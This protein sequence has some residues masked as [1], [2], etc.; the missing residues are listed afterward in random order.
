MSTSS[1]VQMFLDVSALDDANNA[2]PRNV[3]ICCPSV[4][5]L[6]PKGTY[7]SPMSLPKPQNSQNLFILFTCSKLKLKISKLGSPIFFNH[8]SLGLYWKCDK[9]L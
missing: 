6:Y 2:L 5:A 4:T 3:E 8:G 9:S 1:R 7:S